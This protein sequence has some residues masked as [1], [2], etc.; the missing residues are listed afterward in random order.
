MYEN[1]EYLDI[2]KNWDISVNYIS[3]G[4]SVMAIS[5]LLI[6]CHA[7]F[8]LFIHLSVYLSI[9]A[10][11][12]LPLIHSKYGCGSFAMFQALYY[13]YLNE[14]DKYGTDLRSQIKP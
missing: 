1:T 6:I 7:L 12:Y 8:Y 3:Y 2:F 11:V 10:S 4:T 9:H 14:Q 13:G 5:L